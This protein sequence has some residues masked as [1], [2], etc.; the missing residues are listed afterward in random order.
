M[1]RKTFLTR[2]I[3][4]SF[5]FFSTLALAQSDEKLDGNWI[6]KGLDATNRVVVAGNSSD[7]DVIISLN[8]VYYVYGMLAVHR[9]NNVGPGLLAK[10]AQ[11]SNEKKQQNDQPSC[12]DQA[13]RTAL[14]FTPLIGLPDNITPQ[15]IIAILEKYMKS[16]PE[17]WSLDASSL[18]TDALVEA[19]PRSPRR[20]Q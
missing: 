12:N 9:S 13:I 7:E 5:I 16:H 4:A 6:K 10:A 1:F 19:F 3:G 8:L 15:Q 18:I 17:K 2:F 14:L 20:A 11:L